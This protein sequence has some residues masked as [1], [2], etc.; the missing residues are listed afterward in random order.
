MNETRRSV[1]FAERGR[2]DGTAMLWGYPAAVMIEAGIQLLIARLHTE[3][4]HY[5]S[6]AEIREHIYGRRS[7]TPLS[8]PPRSSG[9]M[10]G[11]TLPP[12]RCWPD[13]CLSTPRP[14]CSAMSPTTFALATE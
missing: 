5:P 2:D 11:A 6:S 3:S 1:S 7:P 12:P 9:R 8:T 13:C 4:G 14:H 10:S